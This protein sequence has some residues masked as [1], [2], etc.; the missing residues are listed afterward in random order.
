[1]FQSNQSNRIDVIALIVKS[2]LKSKVVLRLA[3]D[4][5]INIYAV[6]AVSALNARSYFGSTFTD[7]MIFMTAFYSHFLVLGLNALDVIEI[8]SI[9]GTRIHL[10]LHFCTVRAVIRQVIAV[11]A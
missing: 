6:R 1:M 8:L 11:T 2:K 10:M 3:L 7:Q 4:L 9:K 5:V